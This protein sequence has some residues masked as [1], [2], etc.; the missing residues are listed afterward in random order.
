[1]KSLRKRNLRLGQQ[2]LMIQKR[3]VKELINQL[4]IHQLQVNL[5]PEVELV[6]DHPQEESIQDQVL[7]VE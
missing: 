3:S 4:R 6:K 7:E 1:M 5:H 2:T